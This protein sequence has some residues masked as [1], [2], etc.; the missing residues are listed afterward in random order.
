MAVDDFT[1]S[2]CDLGVA[3]NMELISQTTVIQ[4]VVENIED[5][6]KV[7]IKASMCVI[8]FFILTRSELT[9]K[10]S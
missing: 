3:I 2:I 4:Q 6:V 8:L 10:Y 1:A 9:G 5:E 7:I